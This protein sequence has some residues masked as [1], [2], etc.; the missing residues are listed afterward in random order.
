MGASGAQRDTS[1]SSAQRCIGGANAA[2]YTAT[3]P[4]SYT[5][6]VSG[7]CGSPVTS[8]P[9]VLTTPAPVTIT[10]Q[11]QS[12]TFTGSNLLSVGTSNATGY[13]WYFGGNPISGA[14]S[15]TYTA[16]VAGTYKV[17]VTGMCSSQVTSVNM[18]Y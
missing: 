11:P 12:Q 16:T 13:Q 7:N 10:T 18:Q 2:T 14:N 3:S 5:V 17:V 15:Q 9:A 6:V 4:G 1:G 8:N